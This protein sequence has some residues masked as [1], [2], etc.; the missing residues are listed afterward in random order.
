MITVDD[1]IHELILKRK[2]ASNYNRRTGNTKKAN[3]ISQISVRTLS[4]K[5][6]AFKVIYTDSEQQRYLSFAS[7][8]L[9]KVL[10]AVRLINFVCKASVQ[11]QYS[12]ECLLSRPKFIF[13]I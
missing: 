10:T 7:L 11:F 5:Q 13:A 12:L 1:Q 3:K 4:H 6:V 9:C 2:L 8:Q